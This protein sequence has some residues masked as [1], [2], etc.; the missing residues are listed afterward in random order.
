M[1]TKISISEA[2][3]DFFSEEYH[4]MVN[5]VKY[6]INETFYNIPAE[7][8]IQDIALKIFSKPELN[9]PI[10]NIAGYFYQSL[11][12]KIIDIQRKNRLNS[13]SIDLLENEKPGQSDNLE[14]HTADEEVKMLNEEVKIE[15]IMNALK[16]LSPS[17]QAII[18]ETE[19]NNRTFEELSILWDEP[20]GT[21]LSRK[22]RALGKIQKRALQ[23]YNEMNKD[24]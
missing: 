7:D 5:Y 18:I 10:D 22:H 14:D 20:V 9:V 6:R 11:K 3:K 16:E 12:N 2:I 21:L 15:I 17:Q 24:Y 8:I 13:F 23:V 19:F 4:K 1:N